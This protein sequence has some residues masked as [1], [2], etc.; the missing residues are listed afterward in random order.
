MPTEAVSPES[1]HSKSQSR[2]VIA[3]HSVDD[4]HITWSTTVSCYH[5]DLSSLKAVWYAAHSGIGLH[6]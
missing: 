3:G 4:R 5:L 1:Y 2:L 6:Q